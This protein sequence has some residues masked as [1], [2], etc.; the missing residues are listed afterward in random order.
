VQ[1]GEGEIDWAALAEQLARLCPD[2]GF[3][4]EIWMGHKDGGEGFWVANERLEAW[5]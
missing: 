4:P 1:V 3:I 2:A 5:F